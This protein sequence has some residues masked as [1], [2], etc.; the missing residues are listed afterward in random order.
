MRK[1]LFTLILT[2]GTLFLFASCGTHSHDF[3]EKNTD[4]EY[5]AAE[6][7]CE[8]AAK[9]YYSCSCGEKGEKTFTQGSAKPHEFV[10]QSTE[11]RYLASVADCEKAARYYYSC[12]CGLAGT[13]SFESSSVTP[14]AYTVKCTDD[15]YLASLSD[16]DSAAR[17]YFS[18]A[19]GLPGND[20][21]ESGSAKQHEYVVKNTAIKYLAAAADYE[22]PAKYFYSCSCGEAGDQTFDYGS[23]KQHRYTIKNTDSKYLAVA[24]D[25]ENAAQYYFSCS[26]GKAGEETFAAG[27][28]SEF[29]KTENGACSVCGLPE[30]SAGLEF[31]LNPD[32]KSYTVTGIGTCEDDLIVIG[33]YNN[34]SVTAIGNEAFKDL[35]DLVS[36]TLGEKVS[37]IDYR[38]FYGCK[39]LVE[40][41]NHSSLEITAGSSDFGEIAREARTVHSDRS[42]I[43]SKGEY[44]FY[45]N[46]LFNHL[47][48]YTGNDKN[49]TLPDNYNGEN[50]VIY[51]YAFAGR[52]DIV[53]VS[54]GEGV[55]EIGES[56]FESC[57]NLMSITVSKNVSYL[58]HAAFSGCKRLVEVINKSSLMITAGDYGYG[59]VALHAIEVHS[60]ESKIKSAG[61]YIFYSYNGVNYLIV[62]T[63]DDKAVTLPENYNGEQYKIFKGAFSKSFVTEVVISGGVN[64]IGA[65]AFSGCASL[66]RVTIPNSVSAIGTS[67]FSGC[68]SL[69]S[70]TIPNSVSAIGESAFS[71]CTSIESI[72]IPS[73]VI[74]I[75]ENA[76]KNCYQ[77]EDVYITSLADWCAIAF[78]GY[79]A[80]PLFYAE[81]LYLNGALV[82]DLVIDD[83]V[84]EISDY[85][86]CNYTQLNS[87][88]LGDGVVRI[89]TEAFYDCTSLENVTFGL[90]IEA[91]GDGAFFRCNNISDVY[92]EDI[93]VWC[94]ISF[95]NYDSNPLLYA[96]TLYVN[97]TPVSEL[98]IPSG[99]E[100]V[101][102]YAFWSFDGIT[103]VKISAGV[104]SISENAFRECSGILSVEIGDGVNSIGKYAFYGCTALES[105]K[106]GEGVGSVGEDS[107]GYCTSLDGVE[108]GNNFGIIGDGAFEGCKSLKSITIPDGTASIGEYAFRHCTALES[109]TLGA[110]LNSIGDDAFWHCSSLKSIIIPDSVTSI[111]RRV[112]LNC[113]SLTSV[114]IGSGVQTIMEGAFE[115]CKS[116]KSITVPNNV[117]VIGLGVFRG[118]DS[119]ESITLP[120]VGAKASGGRGYENHFGYIFGYGFGNLGSY[121][122]HDQSD[123]NYYSFFIPESLKSVTISELETTLN[124]DAFGGCTSISEF[125]VCEDNPLYKSVDGNLYTKDGEIL[126]QYAIGKDSDSFTVPSGVKRICF[127]AFRGCL[128]LKSVTISKSV[129]DISAGAFSGCKNL[130]IALFENAQGWSV[131]YGGSLSISELQLPGT[132]ATFLTS[133]YVKSDWIK[134]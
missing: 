68:T 84:T 115:N 61:D 37:S 58:R 72:S 87:V 13:D 17:Y 88:S 92:I 128:N 133:T 81:N 33:S 48:G 134:K 97:G 23:V 1:I 41:I 70:V 118:C 11:E 50:Y 102:K 57:S 27:G 78:D 43:D 21:F 99:V 106:I 90:G 51:D 40:V 85:A 124:Y 77:L 125:I 6:A 53:T 98:V 14:H 60:G 24:A 105:L 95:Y 119:L 46:G 5:L 45:A 56:A 131:T 32:G 67:A 3:A 94:G 132:A 80:N 39:K 16:C 52:D 74:S 110:G 120:F 117:S 2:L 47:I 10:L 82:K 12:A 64:E 26:C 18:C 129:I 19:C 30:S 31:V 22:N 71:D 122:Y 121:H 29:H 103:S 123:G 63:G 9:Y 111:S 91:V 38:A 86:F 25:C 75:G 34:L 126:I 28:V 49:L 8:S 55:T 59:S 112:F 113:T 73:S 65:S 44:L 116:L 4:A 109:V 69:E 7:S 76:F 66:E 54:L 130:H 100:S 35:T 107:F 62:Y 96:D 79:Q 36:V 20:T 101:G 83:S 127:E 104:N 42:K 15:K 108:I 93:A 114:A 89:G